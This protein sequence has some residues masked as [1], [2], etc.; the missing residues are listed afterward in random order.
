MAFPLA[1]SP[2]LQA[3]NPFPLSVNPAGDVEAIG[4]A[5]TAF[6]NALLT[7]IVGAPIVL[8]VDLDLANDEVAIGGPDSADVRQ[9]FQGRA[10]GTKNVIETV[11]RLIGAQADALGKAEDTAHVTGDVGVPALAV[12]NDAGG[13]FGDDGD[14]TPLQTDAA[15]QLRVTASAFTSSF[16][17]TDKDVD[18]TG[19]QAQNVS[20]DANIA[21]LPANAGVIRQITILSDQGLAWECQFYSS[22]T[23]RDA[24][25]D[26]DTF[27]EAIKFA[28]GDGLQD[29]GAGL[30]RYSISGLSI[31]Y[32]DADGT[33]E[34]HLSIVNRSAVAK[35][36]GATGEIVIQLSFDS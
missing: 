19:A 4:F 11:P 8:V 30:F 6:G 9:L 35:N 24:D 13:A 31:P 33:L 1:G 3:F 20:A 12:R 28:E 34:A 7:S 10:D 5:V 23:F 14:Y 21:G 27:I 17:R 16:I 22:D 15:G 36:A 25:L 29:N 18:Y 26:V 32:L 2:I